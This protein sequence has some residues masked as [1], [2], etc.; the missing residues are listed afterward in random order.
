MGI[1]LDASHSSNP[2]LFNKVK[3]FVLALARNIDLKSG[4]GRFGLI[5]FNKKAKLQLAFDESS[6]QNL[7]DIRKILNGVERDWKSRLDMALKKANNHLFT[8][9][10]HQDGR[11]KVL[12]ILGDGRFHPKDNDYKPF[13]E[14]LEV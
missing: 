12:I 13:V 2:S 3:E 5:T 7:L 4:A 6:H 9:K 1:I 8:K 14:P 10:V 11:E